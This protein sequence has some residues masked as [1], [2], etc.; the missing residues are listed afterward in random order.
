MVGGTSIVKSDD[1]IGNRTSD[2]PTCGTVPRPNY[3]RQGT[4]SNMIQ[5]LPV[6]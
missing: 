2:L 5:K 3:L 6:I 1:A 4:T